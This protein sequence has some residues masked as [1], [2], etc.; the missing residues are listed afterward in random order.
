M[1]HLTVGW[2]RVLPSRAILFKTVVTYYIGFI[3]VVIVCIT[4]FST[5][6]RRASKVFVCIKSLHSLCLRQCLD[7]G[8]PRSCTYCEEVSIHY[9]HDDDDSALLDLVLYE[10]H[11]FCFGGQVSKYKL[12]IFQHIG[13]GLVSLHAEIKSGN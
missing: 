6:T 11:I 1:L 12:A 4:A 13:V 7:P 5:S 2:Y 9:I 8:G 3:N 10:F